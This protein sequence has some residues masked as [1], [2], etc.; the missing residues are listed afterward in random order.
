DETSPAVAIA[1][2]PRQVHSLCSSS[3]EYRPSKVALN[4]REDSAVKDPHRGHGD[5]GTPL[6]PDTRPLLPLQ[7]QPTIMHRQQRSHGAVGAQQATDH[8]ILQASS[9]SS[10]T[11]GAARG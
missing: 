4:Q 9:S 5:I 6:R 11:F 1:S 10:S 3:S 8:R 2:T 7:P